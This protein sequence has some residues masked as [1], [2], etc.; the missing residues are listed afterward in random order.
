MISILTFIPSYIRTLILPHTPPYFLLSRCVHNNEYAT[1]AMVEFL[2][3]FAFKHMLADRAILLESD[4]VPSVDFY[5]YHQWAYGN[6]FS[7]KNPT[8]FSIR[9]L[10]LHSTNLSDPYTLFPRGFDSYDW[11]SATIRWYWLKHR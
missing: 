6:L 11:L 4:L 5:R 9:S 3:E 2:L 10:N 1:T 7:F 8:V